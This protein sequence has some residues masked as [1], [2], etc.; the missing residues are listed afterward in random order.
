MMRVAHLTTVHPQDDTRIFQR[1]C[2][3]LADH[4]YDTHLVVPTARGESEYTLH[5]VHIHSVKLPRNRRERFGQARRDVARVAAKLQADIY[6]FHDPELMRVGL[7]LRHQA[8]VIYDAHE[9]VAT[10]ILIKAWIPSPLRRVIAAAATAFE[11]YGCRRLAGVVAAGEDIA[12]RLRTIRPDVTCIRNY[13]DLR[14]FERPTDD[15][16]PAP[17]DEHRFLFLGGVDASTLPFDVATALDMLPEE[18][19]AKM[20]WGGKRAIGPRMEMLEQHPGWRRVDYVGYIQ[21]EDLRKHLYAATA[22]LVLYHDAPF[23]YRIRSNRLFESMACGVPVIVP[24]FGEWPAFVDKYQC[25]LAV[26]P[27][28]PGEL[29]AAMRRFIEEPTLRDAMGQR[30]KQA[31]LNEFSWQREFT[32]LETLYR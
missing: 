17:S 32:K 10:D 11:A 16:L 24:R 7:G 8:R 12:E 25:G 27:H 21:F 15:E 29:A 26:N 28:E 18:L 3:S 31:V 1:M 22:A 5:G 13:P 19:H 4:G 23:C 30:G 20:V 9:D 6:H 14:A 2:R